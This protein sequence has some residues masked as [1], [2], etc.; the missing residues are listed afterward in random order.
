MV[1][2]MCTMMCC[3]QDT[4]SLVSLLFQCSTGN[5]Y[6]KL[7][8]PRTN[9]PQEP[10]N[11]MVCITSGIESSQQNLLSPCVFCYRDINI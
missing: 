9:Q 4:F 8:F 2:Y 7:H 3:A 5:Q 1:L 6:N 10:S 11:T